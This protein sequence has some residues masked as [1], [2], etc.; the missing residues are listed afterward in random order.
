[1]ARRKDPEKDFLNCE[2]NAEA[3]GILVDHLDELG[4]LERVDVALIH[5]GR[6]L[7]TQLDFDATVSGNWTRYLDVLESIKGEVGDD[8]L[9]ELLREFAES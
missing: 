8:D 4:R 2:S 6:A 9:E 1:M 7:A 5:A 3:F